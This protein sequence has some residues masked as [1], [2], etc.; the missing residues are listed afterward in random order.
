MKLKARNMFQL[1]I[2]HYSS[3][4]K[5][6]TSEWFLFFSFAQ[7]IKKQSKKHGNIWKSIINNYK[8]A[9]KTFSNKKTE[10]VDFFQLC[11]VL[12]CML[13]CFKKKYSSPLGPKT[14][15]HFL[16]CH[17]RII[18]KGVLFSTRK[19]WKSYEKCLFSDCETS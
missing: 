1:F 6:E 10:N 11:R 18:P 3:W 8:R 14:R 7:K 15:W 17:S 9:V 19:N 4:I 16:L 2:T 12:H 13:S 5:Y